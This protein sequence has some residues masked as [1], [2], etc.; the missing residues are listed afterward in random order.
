MRINIFLI[1]NKVANISSKRG[2]VK[3]KQ[4]AAAAAAAALQLLL[5]N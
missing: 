2:K 5:I 4:T 3:E 1:K